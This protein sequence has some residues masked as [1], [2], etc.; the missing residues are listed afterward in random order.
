MYQFLQRNNKKLMAI[1]AAVLMIAFILPIGMNRFGNQMMNPL[2]GRLN[3]KK[4][5]AEDIHRAAEAWQTAGRLR[6]RNPQYQP[7]FEQFGVQEWIPLPVAMF[8]PDL[9][10]TIGEDSELIYL[11]MKE[12]DRAGVQPDVAAGMLQLQGG[13][14][15]I[16]D[17][18]RIVGPE[19]YGPQAAQVFGAAYSQLRALQEH[20][21]RSL[22]MVKISEPVMRRELA[23][24]TQEVKLAILELPVAGFI[25]DKQ[26]FTDEQV[27][28]QFEKYADVVP[29]RPDKDNPL[30]FGYRTPNGLKLQTI[31]IR[32]SDLRD[33][34]LKAEGADKLR[35]AAY[36]YYIDNPDLFQSIPSTQPTT[37]P[38]D[39]FSLGNSTRRPATGP[40]TRPFTEVEQQATDAVLAPR[41]EQL[42]NT[43]LASIQ[44]RLTA[45]FTAWQSA[46]DSKKPAPTTGFGVPYDSY[47]YLQKLAADIQTRHGVLPAITNVAEFQD[48]AALAKLPGIGTSLLLLGEGQQVDFV[49]YALTR[50]RPLAANNATYAISAMELSRPLVGLDDTTYLFRATEVEQAHKATDLARHREKV[51]D[52]LRLAGAVDKAKA[53]ADKVRQQ[54]DAGRN[55][56]AVAGDKPVVGTD[57]F[58]VTSPPAKYAIAPAST[59][60]FEQ[61]V[62]DLLAKAA[63]E[64]KVTVSAVTA[65]PADR[66]VVVAELVDVRTMAGLPSDS[67]F[68]RQAVRTQI[69]QQFMPELVRD[70]FDFD[71]VAARA[72]WESAHQRKPKKQ[73]D[74]PADA[75]PA[76]ASR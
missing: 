54:L 34:A 20:A 48:R 47:E 66:K 13:N 24:N 44:S 37:Q 27:K 32:K 64:K 12:L 31:A 18:N 68:L 26:T 43:V 63:R 11:L 30:G 4:V 40:T 71:A 65:L 14:I 21:V 45:D 15:G 42:R 58:L 46:V 55:L 52:D 23:L 38:R 51:V 41:V 29:G 53:D 22:S 5:Y 35:V 7:G 73:D 60:A 19:A 50:V 74:Q 1:F 61:L 76:E 67:G 72:G 28:T 69:S 10:R 8:G 39:E 59:P 3:G 62:K 25:D 33:A 17:A 16:A 49:D 2:M 75:A 36:R 56:A 57:Y 6:T 9:A 70:Y